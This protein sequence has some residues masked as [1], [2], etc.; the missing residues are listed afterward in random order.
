[1]VEMLIEA[2]NRIKKSWGEDNKFLN[3]PKL[4]SSE[5]LID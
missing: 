4:A 2:A 3:G 1:M 5:M